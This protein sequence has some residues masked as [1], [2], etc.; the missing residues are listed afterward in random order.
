MRQ[1]EVEE[2]ASERASVRGREFRI[3]RM[4]KGLEKV[5]ESL[6][7]FLGRERICNPHSHP[8]IQPNKIP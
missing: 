2:R 1:K 4:D 3:V 7:I 8:P 5:L 6:L